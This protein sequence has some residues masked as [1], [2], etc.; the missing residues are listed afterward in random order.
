MTEKK[1]EPAEA[2]D[3][4]KEFEVK[5]DEVKDDGKI[6][7]RESLS[8]DDGKAGKRDKLEENFEKTKEKQVNEK[9][10]HGSMLGDTGESRGGEELPEDELDEGGA[11]KAGFE[12]S[13]GDEKDDRFVGDGT[14]GAVSD[15]PGFEDDDFGIVDFSTQDIMSQDTVEDVQ[16]FSIDENHMIFSKKEYAPFIRVANQLM[17][18]GNDVYSKSFYMKRLDQS[19]ITLVYNNGMSYIRSV[20]NT[21]VTDKQILGHYVVGL[22][23]MTKLST[24]G[25]SQIP[26]IE[27]D[28]QLYAFIYGGKVPL[29][30]HNVAVKLYEQHSI[31]SKLVS[32][33]DL[34]GELFIDMLKAAVVLATSG[35]RAEERAC[36]IDEDA[37]YVYSG[38]IV[39]KFEGKFEP[40]VLQLT[41][42]AAI[43]SYFGDV[44]DLIKVKVYE[45]EI[46]FIV[47]ENILVLPRKKLVL[48]P[49]LKDSAMEITDG[50]SVETS[51]LFDIVN[52]LD[53]MPSNS[54]VCNILQRDFGFTIS[55]PQKSGSVKSDF[56]IQAAP[57]GKGITG[58]VR[59]SLKALKV[60]LRAFSGM[61]TVG[62]K[63]NKLIIRGTVGSLVVSGT[64]I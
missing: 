45:K 39:A 33:N 62:V 63:G 55:S 60:Y 19:H 16:T 4:L 10:G 47:L 51:A 20:I 13:K 27:E 29:E 35:S 18:L 22:P 25:S 6:T 8:E 5:E 46:S 30:T 23:T 49:V 21:V 37:A 3:D 61:I 57:I 58:S 11:G 34:N 38:I 28:N 48:D 54:G 52:L 31:K 53:Y 15:E 32:E 7:H 59:I 64:G 36:Y 44:K 43:V 26:I 1:T 50:V 17:K 42:L 12:Y 41:D 24:F 2:K 40:M 14:G 9:D 56:D